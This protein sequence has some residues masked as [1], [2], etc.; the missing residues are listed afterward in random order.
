MV[1][2]TPAGVGPAA[3]EQAVLVADLQRAAQH[4]VLPAGLGRRGAIRDVVRAARYSPR[5]LLSPYHLSY[6]L[7]AVLFPEPLLR[8]FQRWLAARHPG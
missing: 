1:D 5:T 6:A 4:R 2:V 8:T 7:A 3:G